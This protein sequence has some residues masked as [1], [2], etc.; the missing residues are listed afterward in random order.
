MF[1]GA[2]AL[3]GAAFGAGSGQIFLNGID[4]N[5]TEM[6]LLECDF[7]SENECSHNEVAGVICRGNITD[8]LT[9]THTHAHT[10]THTSHAY[11]HTHTDAL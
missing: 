7:V 2:I 9:L 8:T 11:S 4:C 3:G 6:E 1:S 5:G 10:H